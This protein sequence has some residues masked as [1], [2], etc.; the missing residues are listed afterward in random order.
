MDNKYPH[1]IRY[2]AREDLE[3]RIAAQSEKVGMANVLIGKA[4]TR[5][6][7]KFAP[8]RKAR[9]DRIERIG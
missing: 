2:E 9:R 1:G 5:F 4:L 8:R 6:K 7:M 3:E